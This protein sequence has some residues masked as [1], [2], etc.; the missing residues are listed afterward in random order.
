M[1][2]AQTATSL[3]STCGSSLGPTGDCLACLVKLGFDDAPVETEPSGFGDYV[4]AR[5][6]DG[7]RCELG[8]GAMG[9]TYRAVDKVLNRSVAL[10]VIDVPRT[11]G[12]EQPVRERFLREARAAAALHHPNV[13]SVFQ[14]GATREGDRCYYA[15]ELVEG[16]TLDSL[17][18]RDGPMKVEM[19]LDVAMQVTAALVAAASH[20]LVHRD[21]K[22][23]NIM[24]TRS[25]A[26]VDQASV[27][28]I[29][30]GLAKAVSDSGN[31]MDLTQGGFV[32]TPAFASPEQFSGAPADARSDIYSLGVTLWYALTG[33]APYEGTSIDEIRRRQTELP[34]PVARL[35]ERKIPKPVIHLLRGVLSVNP[36][37]RPASARELMAELE[38]C[39]A[40]LEN[41]GAGKRSRLAA[42]A[43]VLGTLAVTAYLALGPRDES[44]RVEAAPPAKSVA[45]LPFASL[46]EDETNSYFADGVQD[47]ILTSLAKIADLKVTSRTSVMQFRNAENRSVREIAGQ[48]G[49]AHVLQGTV[50][51]SGDRVRV[52]VQLIDARDDRHVWAESYDK[53]ISDALTLQGELAKE[54]AGALHATLSPEEKATVERKLTD[55]ADA[56]V[57]YLK[58]RQLEYNPDTRFEDYKTAVQL[59]QQAVELDPAF[60]VARARLAAVAAR[61]YHFYEPTDA[62]KQR[63][64]AE[65]Q[66][67]LRLQPKLGEAHFARGLFLYW[68]E[69]D[70]ARA[71]QELRV[72]QT[73]MPSNSEVGT[74]LGAIARREGRWEEA[75]ATFR[76]MEA[77]DP[78]NPNI[79]R[80]LVYVHGAVR[81]W[82]EAARAGER[83]HGL[84]PGSISVRIQVAYIYY[85][86][87]GSTA[88]LEALLATAPPGSDPDGVVTAG[89]WDVSMIKR[90]FAGAETVLAAAPAAELSYLQGGPLPKSYFAGCAALARGDEAT[91]QSQFEAARPSFEAAVQEAPQ[92]AA[93]HANLGLLYAFMG[94]KEAA[95]AEGRRA[96]ELKP[97][98]RDAV[99]G[100]LM[101]G[102]LALIYTRVGERDL[103]L[104]LIERLLHTPHATDSAHYSVSLQDLRLRWEWDPLRNDPRFEK[105]IAPA[106]A[107]E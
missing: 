98:S 101:N 43:A 30:F 61:I 34:L 81:N 54:I 58:A 32:G 40:S 102:Y 38:A 11:A 5:R 27:K 23:G 17:V 10:K 75:V 9:V 31:D 6:G 93:R 78:Q 105:L 37:E 62:W 94:R 80:N 13:A 20:G 41:A 36:A 51:R 90:D 69:R 21:L 14:F 4:I 19:A 67:S 63:A 18:R 2:A 91:A 52:A 60:A 83:L 56:Y 47:E 70:Y 65:I 42:V 92:D 46:S 28:V 104:A 24:L 1:E 29:D 72:A 53:A 39:R 12:N 55:N 64:A 77:T 7:S 16:E 57:L 95:I 99:D 84:A 107:T 89:R 68:L 73:L 45:V 82:A 22:P 50:R 106:G 103:A 100:P 8:R 3:C 35:A 66:E 48:L 49:V 59:Y 74:I 85:F 44:D 33:E 86:W 97:E 25:D 26:A 79:V 88:E 15:M 96:V 87:R 76:Q 71:V